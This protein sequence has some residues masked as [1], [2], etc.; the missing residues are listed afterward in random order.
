MY[1]ITENAYFY[2]YNKIM[3]QLEPIDFVVTGANTNLAILIKAFPNVK[4]KIKKYPKVFWY[5]LTLSIYFWFVFCN[6]QT[7]PW[8]CAFVQVQLMINLPSD[9]A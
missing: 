5:F 1:A 2:M 3:E 9:L 8:S 6:E 7:Q 4:N